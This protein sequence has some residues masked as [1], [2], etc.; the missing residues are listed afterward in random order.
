MT[1]DSIII[2]VTFEHFHTLL[3]ICSVYVVLY[4]SVCGLWEFVAAV[5]VSPYADGLTEH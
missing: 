2:A 1:I 5:K 4:L 3:Y